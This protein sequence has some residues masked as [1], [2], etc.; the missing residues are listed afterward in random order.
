MTAQAKERI[1]KIKKAIIPILREHNIKRASLFGSVL[2]EDFDSDSDIDLLVELNPEYKMS[3]FKLAGME[4][5]LEESLNRKVDVVEYQS[6]KPTLRKY[7]L[8]NQ[9]IIY[10]ENS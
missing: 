9:Q 8:P 10:E 6:I 7:I 2:R 3:L 1:S 4:I 5:N